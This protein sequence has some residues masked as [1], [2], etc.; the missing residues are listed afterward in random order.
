M[1]PD[2]NNVDELLNS[3]LDDELTP[4]QQTEVQRLLAHDNKIAEKL[5]ELEKC[6]MLVSSLP[7]EQAPAEMAED[8]KLA[9]ERRTLLGT[10][11]E[12]YNERKGARHLLFRK[13]T[14]AA[15][16]IGLIAALGVVIYNIV[17][18]VK[19]S[20][21][22]VALEDSIVPAV[23]IAQ[24]EPKPAFV[25]VAKKTFPAKVAAGTEFNGKLE[26]I[27]ADVETIATM[28]NKIVAEHGLLDTAYPADRMV[29]SLSCSREEFNLVLAD[30][31]FV[32]S[33][34]DFARFVI[35]S[36]K[37]GSDIVVEDAGVEQIAEIINQTDV[38][39]RNKAAK[40]F[41]ILNNIN[42]MAAIMPRG[43][44]L[45]NIDTDI[46]SSLAIPKPVLTSGEQ[47]ESGKPV[48]DGQF[49]LTIVVIP[50]L[51]IEK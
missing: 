20:G 37:A 21:K 6:K 44:M 26:L 13:I 11:P 42:N 9:L 32:W 24:P 25:T 5:E 12:D 23:K 22:P 18:P 41:A 1:N 35:K 8:V 14:A 3:Y 17:A 47:V 7:F 16:M 33:K 15:A 29:S 38:E 28:V 49:N 45:S 40:Y 46:P 31:R 30:L 34:L 4:R 51:T 10:E 43:D 36:D 39:R 19:P 2:P 27:A 50:A 48:D